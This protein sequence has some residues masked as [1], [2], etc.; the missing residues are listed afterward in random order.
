M[1]DAARWGVE[2]GYEDYSGQWRDTP[3]HAVEAVLAAMGAGGR[4]DP[5]GL[6]DDTPVRVVTAGRSSSLAG[7]WSLRTEDGAE[8]RVEGALPLDVPLGY[9]RLEREDDGHAV[10][11]V[12]APPTCVLPDD[13]RTWG[14]A[15]Q[16]YAARSRSSWGMGDLADLRR[17]GRWSAGAGAG[18]AMINPLHAVLPTTP[19]QSSP[20]SPSSRCFRNPLYL[21]V[22]EIPGAAAAG[23]DLEKLAAAGRALNDDRR[24]DRDAVLRL[25]MDALEGIWSAFSGDPGFAR[26]CEQEG[27]ALAGFATFCV[28]TEQHGAPWTEWPAGLR[29]PDGGDVPA[30]VDRH[31]DRIR[32]HQWLQWLLDDQL[33]AAGG[34]IALVQDLAIGVDPAGADAWLWQDCFALD[35]RVGAPPDEFA[36]QGQDWG[37]PPFDPW[38]LRAAGYEPFVRT[39]RAGFRHGGGLRVDHVMGLFRLYWI[40]LGAGA[41]D[42]AYVRYPCEELLGILALESTRAGAYVVGEDLGTVE[43][44]VREELA[45]R[46]VLSYRLVWFEDSPPPAFP[47]Q[48]LAAVTTHDLPTV[49]GLWTGS[50]L[51]EQEQLG[52]DPNVESTKEIRRRLQEWIGAADDEAVDEVVRRTYALVA[53]APSMVV[54]ATLDDALSVPDR[55]N[56]P[57]T[58]SERPNWCLALPAP[59]EE[60]EQDPRVA[61]VADAMGR[62]PPPPDAP[63][64]DDPPFPS[65]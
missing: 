23:A 16:L 21:R 42:G 35:A 57:G 59:L 31:R 62:R 33:A 18:V 50:D 7:R 53:D 39:L 5:P 52:L 3:P 65:T 38:K 46:R 19:Q 17:L 20:Y 43:D 9:H 32:F 30:F 61:A 54:A 2:P 1:S 55:P 6:G 64:P 34:E 37:L 27:P 40:P 10:R 51:E 4:P 8:A 60:V 48:A 11:L 22:E 29:D 56:M 26:Y 41:T 24:I 58:T 49:A 13:L 25:K 36:R 47:A 15:V 63:G 14:W 45:R 28:L 44:F 12:V